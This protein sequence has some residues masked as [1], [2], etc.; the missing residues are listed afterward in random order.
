MTDSALT[1]EQRDA[2]AP[3]LGKTPSG[4]FI[5]TASDGEENETGML[6]SWVQQASFE[7]PILSV[8]VN[9]KRYLKD[10]LLK[11]PQAALSLVG[12]ASS[13]TFFKK[14][15][16]GF[17]PG[18]PAFEGMEI[19]R[20]TTGV[21]LLADSIGALEGRIVG[22][23]EAGDHVVFFLQI[24]N[25]VAGSGFDTEEPYVHIRKNGFNY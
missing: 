20:G 10:W 24:E 3:I 18:E 6:A 23:H 11:S 12:K 2:I 14:Y 21:P 1:D 19:L 4:V 22:H 13:G 25:A 5:L 8:A 17:E 16:K 15:G 9:S 7:P